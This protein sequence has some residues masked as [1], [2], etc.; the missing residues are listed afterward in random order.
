M[1]EIRDVNGKLV[2]RVDCKHGIVEIQK[3]NIKTRFQLLP[4]GMVKYLSGRVQT[5]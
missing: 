3:N 2:C 1:E 5:K 4:E